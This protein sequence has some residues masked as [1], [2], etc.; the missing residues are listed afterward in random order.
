MMTDGLWLDTW[1]RM[2]PLPTQYNVDLWNGNS[3]A[4][5]RLGTRHSFPSNAEYR[6]RA[7]ATDLPGALNMA[8]VDGHAEVVKLNDINQY[9]WSA[10]YVP[11]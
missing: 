9:S 10:L 4:L 6:I 3:T 1:I 8:M 2:P 5:G 11:K 7:G